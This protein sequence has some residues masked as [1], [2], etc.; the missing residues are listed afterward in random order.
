MMPF[1]LPSENTGV[2]TLVIESVARCVSTP[3][4][5]AIAM[6][7][8]AFRTLLNSHQAQAIRD[9]FLSQHARKL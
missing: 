3:F 6:E 7:H 4:P 2:L 5:V 1:I 8:D 9:E